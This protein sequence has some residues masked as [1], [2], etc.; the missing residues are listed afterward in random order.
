MPK[1]ASFMPSF[2]PLFGHSRLCHSLYK[3]SVGM[4][5]HKGCFRHPFMSVVALHSRALGNVVECR[6]MWECPKVIL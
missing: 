3:N 5:S 1:Y 4:P 2:L 6:G